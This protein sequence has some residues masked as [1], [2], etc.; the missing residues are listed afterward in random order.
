MN[1]SLLI[2]LVDQAIGEYQKVVSD[3]PSYFSYGLDK[4]IPIPFFGDL[5]SDTPKVLTFGSNPSDNEFLKRGKHTFLPKPRFSSVGNPVTTSQAVIMD[6]CEYFRVN[7]Y[8]WFKKI[9]SVPAAYISSHEGIEY[10]HVDA[11]PFATSVKFTK[12]NPLFPSHAG[13]STF[14]SVLDWGQQYLRELVNLIVQ[15]DSVLYIS[16]VGR[17]NWEQFDTIF[18]GHVSNMKYKQ[19][20][21]D[22]LLEQKLQAKGAVLIEG[23]KWCGK[24]TTANTSFR[25]DRL[26]SKLK[27][28]LTITRHSCYFRCSSNAVIMTVSTAAIVSQCN[29]L[30]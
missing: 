19:R 4:V 23:P 24:T 28:L 5:S 6:C 10:I 2:P 9:H 21:A 14:Q 17:T 30:K 15:N 12:L 29:L 1:T 27:E 26:Y 18:S 22:A 7:P 16:I 13:G 25:D 3:Y 20:I 8:Y 11:M